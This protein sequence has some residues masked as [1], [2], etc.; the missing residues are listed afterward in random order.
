DQHVAAYTAQRVDAVITFE[1]MASRLRALG[2]RPLLD[3]SRFPGLIV[4][5]LAVSAQITPHQG[6]QLRQLLDG[7]F[8]ALQHLRS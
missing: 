6:E 8:Q 2:A 1:P 3:S 7:H 5:V 4:D